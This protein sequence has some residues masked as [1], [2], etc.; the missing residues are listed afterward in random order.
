MKSFEQLSEDIEARRAALKQ[1]QR[2]QGT[3]FKERST[4]TL[5]ASRQRM[6][7]QRTRL[8][9]IQQKQKEKHIKLKTPS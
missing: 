6:S 2:E 9:N 8:T 5:D 7:A 1:R 3:S 4:G